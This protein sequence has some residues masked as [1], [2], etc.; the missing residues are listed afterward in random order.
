MTDRDDILDDKD[1]V[2]AEYVLGTLD[3]DERAAADRLRANDKDV[4]AAIEEWEMRLAPLLSYVPE[5]T[6]PATVFER[7][8]ERLDRD[9]KSGDL[10][11]ARQPTPAANLAVERAK[12][13]GDGWRNVA[14]GALA[15]AAGLLVVVI[16]PDV[17]SQLGLPGTS[18]G[19]ENYVAVFNAGDTQPAFVL[20]I[21]LQTK[22]LTVRPVDAVPLTDDTY[23][24]WIA[25]DPAAPTPQSLG[26]LKSAET[27]KT[28][29]EQFET[30][31]LKRA[32]F[33]I[34]REPAGGSPTGQPTN[35]ALHG[36]LI[37]VD[38]AR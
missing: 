9:G 34:S 18:S 13:R 28:S 32:T 5:T 4:N 22:A 38:Q 31:V 17:R 35:P 21:N 20:S 1:G 30:S 19:A 8:L 23:Q 27:T 7:I 24:L 14:V 36:T 11:N 25:P 10:A 15:L 3:A 37:P 16:S 26:L 6:P 33:G 2:A 29:L 12:R